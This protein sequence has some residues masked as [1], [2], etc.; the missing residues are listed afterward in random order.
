M[1]VGI[2]S[3]G[4]ACGRQDVPG[5]YASVPYGFDFIAWD[6]FCQYGN[7]YSNYT[8]SSQNNN[9]IKEEILNLKAIPGAGKYIRS[10]MDLQ[11]QCIRS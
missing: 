4:V 10:A 6:N 1:Q 5:I 2:I 7:K 8:N 11:S 3:W 9:W